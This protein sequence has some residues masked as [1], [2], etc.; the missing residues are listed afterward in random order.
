VL[1]YLN[2]GPFEHIPDIC[3]FHVYV[4]LG[5]SAAGDGVLGAGGGDFS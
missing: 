5:V 2:S 4:L 3:L 1:N